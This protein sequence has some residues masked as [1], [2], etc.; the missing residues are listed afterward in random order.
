MSAMDWLLE[1]EWFKLMTEPA[2]NQVGEGVLSL[3]LTAIVLVPLWLRSGHVT[4]PAIILVLFSGLLIPILP[5][6]LIGIMWGIVWIAGS[7]ALFG[8]LQSLR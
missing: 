4:I 3:F 2:V 8:I 6:N 1:G 7:V 5:G